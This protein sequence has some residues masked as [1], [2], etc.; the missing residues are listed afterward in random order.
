MSQQLPAQMFLPSPK[1]ILCVWDGRK[2]KCDRLLASC[3]PELHRRN[4]KLLVLYVSLM[5]CVYCL[6]LKSTANSPNASTLL[7]EI[8]EGWNARNK[9]YFLYLLMMVE[10]SFRMSLNLE[11]SIFFQLGATTSLAKVAFP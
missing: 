3:K 11:K 10:S 8:L 4:H 6:R 7:R 9:G 5:S 2:A 1:K